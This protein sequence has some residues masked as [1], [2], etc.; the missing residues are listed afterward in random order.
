ME[1]RY[2]TDDLRAVSGWLA[3][4]QRESATLR[5]YRE[6]MGILGGI[7]GSCPDTTPLPE[8]SRRGWMVLRWEMQSWQRRLAAMDLQPPSPGSTPTGTP[9][10]PPRHC[11]IA[12]GWQ[13]CC[14]PAA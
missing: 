8:N 14:E 7:A 12:S 13:N 1:R 11:Q 6:G 9:V 5:L 2:T 3:R 4:A 10:A